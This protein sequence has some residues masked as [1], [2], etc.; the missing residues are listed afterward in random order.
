MTLHVS[1]LCY[2]FGESVFLAVKESDRSMKGE[3]KTVRTVWRKSTRDSKLED[4]F[5]CITYEGGSWVLSSSGT[6]L[7]YAQDW[8]A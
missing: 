6:I 7:V 4:V 1:F 8:T 5:G 3:N 2:F